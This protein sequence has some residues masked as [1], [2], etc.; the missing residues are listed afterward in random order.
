MAYC[1]VL[2]QQEESSNALFEKFL[3][4]KVQ[5]LFGKGLIN[6][7]NVRAY[8]R[9][10]KTNSSLDEECEMAEL[11][12]FKLS[13]IQATSTNFCGLFHVSCKSCK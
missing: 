10:R 11:T 12:F 2:M 7:G 4:D 5:R 8:L 9:T 6:G 13:G 3:Q 1:L